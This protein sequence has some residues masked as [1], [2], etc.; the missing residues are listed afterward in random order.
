MATSTI[1][2]VINDLKKNTGV[3]PIQL[4]RDP[5]Q[6]AILSK[7]ISDNNYRV[8]YDRHGNRKAFQPDINFL[9]QLSRAKMQD[10][11]DA[12]TVMQLLPDI[13]LSSQILISSILSPKD[14]LTTTLSYVPP[15]TVCPPDVASSLIR[16]IKQYFSLNYKIESKLPKM[17]K[18]ILYEKGSYA[19][20][21]LPENAIDEVINN[22]QRLS[23]EDFNN[24]FGEIKEKQSLL[25]PLGILGKSD[26]K[27][28]K[29]F[30][31][32]N[33]KKTITSKADSELVFSLEELNQE[34]DLDIPVGYDLTSYIQVSDNFSILSVPRLESFLRA[35]T[36]D[37]IIH[38]QEDTYLAD[39]DLD[40]ILYRRMYYQSNTLVQ[41]KTNDQG[42]RK[43][44]S[45]PL[46]MHLPSESVIPVFVPGNPEEHVG[47]FVLID[48]AGNPVSKETSIDYYNELNRMTETNRKCLTSHLL[49]KAKN[50]YDGRGDQGSLM[51][52]RNR[53]DSAART[54]ASIIEKDLIQRLRNGIYGKTFSIGGSDEI[55]RIMFSRALAQQFTQLLFV[56]VELM[57][58]MAFKYDENG[59][60]VS[61]LDNL[62]TVNSLAISLM[63]ANNR[64]AVMNSIPRTKVT[65]KLDE[66]DPDV[67]A[68]R[69]QIVT[70]YMLLKAANSV[71]IGVINPVDIA[72]WASQ[73]NVEFQF[74][75]AKD[76]PDMSIDISEFASQ[77]P[78]ADTDLEEDLRKRRIM[79]QG[80]SPETVDASRGAEFATSIVQESMLFA[81]RTMQ[82]QQKFTPFIADN[83]KKITLATPMLMQDLEE[84]LYNNYDDVIKHLLPE[85]QDYQ[86]SQDDKLRIVRKA[87]IAFVKQI[88]VELPKPNNLSVLRKK[89]AFSDYIDAVNTAVE[90]YISS[91]IQDPEMLGELANIVEPVKKMIVAKMARDWMVENDYLP[92]LNDL[93]SQDEEGK[94]A[95]DIYEVTADFS[96][97]IIK[98]LGKFYDKAKVMKKLS[99]MYAKD[100]DIADD[101]GFGGSSSY[102]SDS[103]SDDSSSG[104]DFAS[105]DDFG[106]DD[107]GGDMGFPDMGDM[108]EGP[109]DDQV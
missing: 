9:K 17:L 82:Y 48:E 44:I 22:N 4:I 105:G 62:K 93:I 12:E 16:V 14:M 66:D 69:E 91:E 72:T 63:L 100:N 67:E 77:V 29:L 109:S 57:T 45:E 90:Y 61:L 27:E 39:R 106:M 19:V 46:V 73:A 68:R 23:K 76:M 108:E 94:P 92:E 41:V 96:S 15:E 65:V 83:I 85:R 104:D 71:P 7:A 81:R 24:L 84:I 102:D 40:N 88:E 55:F 87:A 70:E 47:Y 97:N 53:Y 13:E 107:L 35:K 52:A 32:E 37:E 34:F 64:A 103:S 25:S 28:H 89:E 3:Q 78:K 59:M 101:G 54:Y 49:D 98:S 20:C 30:S 2:H 58:Y 42:Y 26:R 50:L 60:G 51:S 6:S 80:M 56:P 18:D 86:S 21:V 5:I 8:E 36:L 74:E 10:I 33:Y 99:D 95:F 1:Q 38:S 11:A 31:I 75:G 79:G 43:S